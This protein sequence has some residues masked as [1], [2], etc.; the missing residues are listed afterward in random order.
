MY[1][2]ELN[3]QGYFDKLEFLN[4]LK[5]LEYWR[6]PDYVQFIVYVGPNT[7]IRTGK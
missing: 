2:T 1:L 4:Y 7:V 5:Y 6:E 3:A